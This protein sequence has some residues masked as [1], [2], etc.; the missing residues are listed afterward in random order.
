MHGHVVVGGV[1]ELL[2]AVAQVTTGLDARHEVLGRRA[3]VEYQ[4]VRWLGERQRP[5][6]VAAGRRL[7][8][9]RREPMQVRQRAAERP[10]RDAWEASAMVAP[11]AAAGRR[12]QD[13][14]AFR[15]LVM[16]DGGHL[17][18]HV[19]HLGQRAEDGGL[20]RERVGTARACL[21]D[22]ER[23]AGARG[24]DEHAVPAR[25]VDD[26]EVLLHHVARLDKAERQE[27]VGHV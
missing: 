12:A 9:V 21:L 22:D 19:R 16:D 8:R 7:E 23:R 11:V 25:H 14:P 24:S 3:Q 2:Q 20:V 26:D 4:L 5:H 1:P 17:A 18:R 10:R 27:I 6:P 13:Q 15:R